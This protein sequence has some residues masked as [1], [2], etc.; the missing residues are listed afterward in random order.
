MK[1]HRQDDELPLPPLHYYYLI[2]TFEIANNNSNEEE[3]GMKKYP[4]I[5]QLVI[6]ALPSII[7]F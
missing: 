7:T 4:F 6:I 1:E 2:F 5:P 3:A